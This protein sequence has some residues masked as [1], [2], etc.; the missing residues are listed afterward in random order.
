MAVAFLLGA[1][2]ARYGRL[3]EILEND[4]LQGQN[5]YPRTV[6]TAYNLL[7]NWKQDPCNSMRVL[8]QVNDGVSFI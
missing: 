2:C 3:I 1:D 8:G 5:K 7:S 6:T 4:Y